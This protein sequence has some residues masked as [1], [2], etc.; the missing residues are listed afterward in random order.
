[1]AG[2]QLT[3]DREIAQ[4]SRA[5]FTWECSIDLSLP[6]PVLARKLLAAFVLALPEILESAED[7]A[8]VPYGGEGST[9]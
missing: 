5:M 1:M 7:L 9:P 3:I 6:G 8:A 2:E 4:R